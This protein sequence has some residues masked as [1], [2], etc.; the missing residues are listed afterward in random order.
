MPPKRVAIV[1][2]ARPQ[3][4]KTAPIV[5]ELRRDSKS[6]T[7]DLI[8]TGQHYDYAM[9]K[10]FFQ[11]LRIPK[12]D[13]NLR[14]GSGS[15]AE[16]VG[17]ML[18]KL[19]AELVRRRPDIVLVAGDANTTLA[20]A[21]AAAKLGI[22]L[23]HVEAGLRS[24]DLRMPEEINRRLTDHCSNILF[25]PTLTAVRNLLREN[26]VRKSIF[27]VGDTMVDILNQVKPLIA[28]RRRN[29]IERFNLERDAFILVTL[30]R[31]SNVDDPRR[32]RFIFS[33]LLRM[34]KK[35]EVVF[36]VHPRTKA[37]MRSFGLTP[38]TGAAKRLHF[39]DPVGYVDNLVL[40][41][42]ARLVLTD[43]GGLQKEAY[44]LGTPCLT[45]RDNTEW[46]ETLRGGANTLTK[47]KEL[48]SKAERILM[49]RGI[50]KRIAGMPN[51]FGKGDAS[52]RIVQVLRR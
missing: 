23:A 3:F 21:L 28:R 8:H 50:K 17:K 10:A 13:V 37:R 29:T 20:G 34:S 18:L 4:I 40:A 9:S 15:H 45:L 51:P 22:S 35:I 39:S 47:P 36:P 5:Q 43:S 2:G 46:P 31:P 49:Q 42:E 27:H 12:P 52:K 24:G 16:Q 30:H 19:E 6:F 32:F 25:A 44:L 33:S 11:E 41:K 38:K 26:V 14:V 7:I 1:F 48:L